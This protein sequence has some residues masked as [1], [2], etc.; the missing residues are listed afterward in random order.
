MHDSLFTQ[1]QTEAHIL[2]SKVNGL[3][4]PSE[5]A[6]RTQPNVFGLANMVSHTTKGQTHTHI[7]AYA[8]GISHP[9]MSAE[10]H[11][12]TGQDRI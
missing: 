7:N 4:M 3:T 1:S 10:K 12:S 11:R 9:M 6:T 8:I 2:H 5:L